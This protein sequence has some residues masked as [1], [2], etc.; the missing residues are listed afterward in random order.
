M[1]AVAIVGLSIL[2]IALA[3]VPSASVVL[4]VTRSASYGASSGIAVSVGI[5]LGDLVFL[6]LAY[7]G[8]SAMAET[9]G[10][11]FI[12]IKYLGGAYLIWLGVTF[13]RDRSRKQIRPSRPSHK[14]LMM[15]MAGGFLLTLGDV[16]AIFFYASLLP[17]VT[18]W[19]GRDFDSFL[20]LACI[21]VLSVGGVKILYAIMAEKLMKK[22]AFIRSDGMLTSAS[23]CLLIGSGSY[24]VLKA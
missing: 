9:V 22:M 14:S 13:I 21:T 17:I 16:K 2:M 15:S 18:D 20:T 7:T 4:V 8:M 19:E 10:T 1:E 12:F 11:F 3:S 23:G 24:L 5:V 6:A